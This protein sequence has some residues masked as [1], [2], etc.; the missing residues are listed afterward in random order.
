MQ[1]KRIRWKLAYHIYSERFDDLART[2]TVQHQLSQF[3]RY[4]Y[5]IRLAQVKEYAHFSGSIYWCVQII[6]KFSMEFFFSS[7][8]PQLSCR[9]GWRDFFFSS[10]QVALQT[11]SDAMKYTRWITLNAWAAPSF[12]YKTHFI[13]LRALSHSLFLSLKLSL[14]CIPPSPTVM[15][16]FRRLLS[17]FERSLIIWKFIRMRESVI[18]NQDKM[19][20][21]AVY[22]LF[23]WWLIA[24]SWD[25]MTNSQTVQ[26]LLLALQGQM[27]VWCSIRVNKTPCFDELIAF[28]A[29]EF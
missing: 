11:I 14:S 1:T 16:L 8:F 17:C 13:S 23:D 7:I 3:T 20:S 21:M 9:F 10:E 28:N 22:K 12:I 27:P 19:I 18:D 2:S 26:S 6:W 15:P 5:I 29:I 24:I 25:R 4:S